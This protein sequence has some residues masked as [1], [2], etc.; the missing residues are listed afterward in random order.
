[1][2]PYSAPYKA[3]RSPYGAHLTQRYSSVF[4]SSG[5]P[6]TTAPSAA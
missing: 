6:R 3:Y 5:S 1:M 2:A 4:G